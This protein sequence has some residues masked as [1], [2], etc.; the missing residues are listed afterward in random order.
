MCNRVTQIP[1]PF[2]VLI[3]EIFF[4][5]EVV[6]QREDSVQYQLHLVTPNEFILKAFLRHLVFESILAA[7]ASPARSRPYGK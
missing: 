5:H 2:S 1:H 7:V 6:I 4:I 3:L